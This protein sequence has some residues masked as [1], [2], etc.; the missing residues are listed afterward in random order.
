MYHQWPIALSVKQSAT[1][2]QNQGLCTTLHSLSGSSNVPDD[3]QRLGV[4]R[5]GGAIIEH[6]MLK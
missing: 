5:L 2:W 4:I 1:H 6:A 3:H